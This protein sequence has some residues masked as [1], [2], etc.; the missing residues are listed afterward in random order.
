MNKAYGISEYEF[1]AIHRDKN[2]QHEEELKIW[3]KQMLC[4]LYNY[5][6]QEAETI[7][8]LDKEKIILRGENVNN[9]I[10]SPYLTST[11]K[12]N[13]IEDLRKN[14]KLYM[15]TF[16]EINI[17]YNLFVTVT[18]IL[19]NKIK[20]SRK[21]GVREKLETILLDQECKKREILDELILITLVNYD[22]KRLRCTHYDIYQ[23]NEE[24]KNNLRKMLKKTALAQN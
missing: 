1:L 24:D 8:R 19:K 18:N 2:P 11:Q 9:Y 10:F 12:I 6:D 7:L 3:N 17:A 23:P 16:S 14:D 22:S 4:S 20:L 5:S 13:I 21:D 15:L